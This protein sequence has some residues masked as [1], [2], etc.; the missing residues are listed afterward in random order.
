ML[1]KYRYKFNNINNLLRKS[2]IK[3][4]YLNIKLKK[5]EIIISKSV[6]WRKL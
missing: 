3:L 4:I 6:V 1:N 2:T 5:K